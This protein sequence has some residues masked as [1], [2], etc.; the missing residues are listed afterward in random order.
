MK[1]GEK[2]K[3]IRSEYILSQSELAEKINFTKLYVNQVEK[4]QVNPSNEFV[5]RVAI[6]FNIAINILLNPNIPINDLKV[7]RK[8]F[9]I[10]DIRYLIKWFKL[11]YSTSEKYLEKLVKNICRSLNLRYWMDDKDGLVI[12]VEVYHVFEQ[13]FENEALFLNDG[14]DAFFSHKDAFKILGS[15]GSTFDVIGNSSIKKYKDNWLKFVSEIKVKFYHRRAFYFLKRDVMEYK[16][17][18][19]TITEI[20][21]ILRSDYN[22]QISE[23]I[24]RRVLSV[25]YSEF[26]IEWLPTNLKR[27]SIKIIENLV[28]YFSSSNTELRNKFS[29]Q[30]YL[31]LHD[32][33]VLPITKS[34]LTV[35]RRTY[36]NTIVIICKALNLDYEDERNLKLKY[37]DDR[38]GLT[39]GKDVYD[40]LENFF[41]NQASF[42]K[43]EN[44][45]ITFNEA[46]KILCDINSASSYDKKGDKSNQ[47]HRYNWLSFI[48]FIPVKFH[49][50]S[51]FYFLKSDVLQFKKS[52]VTTDEI[53]SI[54]IK[55]FN[56]VV[57]KTHLYRVLKSDYSD[58]KIDWLS[59]EHKYPIEILE[60]L[61]TVFPEKLI[62][63][64]EYVGLEKAAK[65]IGCNKKTLAD[66]LGDSLIK[67][68]RNQQPLVPIDIIN[69]W[70]EFKDETMTISKLMNNL[71][72]KSDTYNSSILIQKL[73]EKSIRVING[74]DTP[75]N[76]PSKYVYKVDVEQIKLLFEEILL[77]RNT[78][79]L[80][81]V[82]I[83]I[84][85]TSRLTND[86]APNTMKELYA[87]SIKRLKLKGTYFSHIFDFYK[88]I[89][90]IE[91]EIIDF[92]DNE[93]KTLLASYSKNRANKA[94]LGVCLFLTGLQNKYNTKY[95][96]KYK[97]DKENAY[98]TGTRNVS[99]YTEEQYFRFGFLILNDTHDW[100]EGYLEKALADYSLSSLW[101][102]GL[103]HYFCAWRRQ[104][105]I[106]QLPFPTLNMEPTV[107]LSLIKKNQFTEEMAF[108]ISTEVE[109]K[110]RYLNQQ[111]LK[112]T[113]RSPPNLVLEVPESA[114]FKFG[115]LLGICEAFRQL[116]NNNTLLK[117][118]KY[119]IKKQIEFFGPEFS[120]IFGG[121]GL[122]NLRLNK[123]FEILIA[124]KAD[125]KKIGTGYIIASFARSHKCKEHQ[126]SNTT[127]VYL[128]DYRT[129][130]NADIVMRELFERG[131]SSFVPYLVLKIINGEENVR[132]KPLTTQTQMIKLSTSLHAYDIETILEQ[133]NEILEKA[134][135][136]ALSIVKYFGYTNKNDDNKSI[137]N[138]VSKDLIYRFLMELLMALHQ[139]GKIILNC[140]S[141]AKG[142]GCIDLNRK[143]CIGCGQEIY[144]K[145]TIF[146]IGQKLRELKNRKIISKT[147]NEKYK[148]EQLID[149]MFK[150]V[151]K[152]ILTILQSVYGVTDMSEYRDM[153]FK[154]AKNTV[155]DKNVSN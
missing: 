29:V 122:H 98:N 52:I 155:G 28:E 44:E 86:K 154:I 79:K 68:H 146:L 61:K 53:M 94:S 71:F 50:K 24:L 70:I 72:T 65:K 120:D 48:E 125:E 10:K 147:E 103:L 25:K 127:L 89:S 83:F 43:K 4:G 7:S 116:T 58:Q 106:Q 27:Y 151:L 18:I 35:N 45:Y 73:N 109:I 23:S 34:K 9:Y 145:S 136:K 110:F 39:F 108:K 63:N 80:S 14:L 60:G 104:D 74:K 129:L 139:L 134:K 142:I 13:F 67:G 115:M 90:T 102:Y 38:A 62:E 54:F 95:K 132:M 91:K 2:I 57:S 135:L 8:E 81:N 76:T 40:V 49:Y 59:E 30:D 21:S 5:K 140:I 130:T 113:K 124:K 42:L 100:Y 85:K 105:M 64:N 19:V 137:D 55:E 1:I 101:L 47:K 69:Y 84:K 114:R 152:E 87:F 66:F 56:L 133:S 17:R 153:V 93:I 31:Q 33:Y 97:Y 138:E 16:N 119:H 107:F 36:E 131:V 15:K 118:S 121:E 92:S 78:Y 37:K 128:E 111:P 96:E 112:T 82:D 3:K 12:D 51:G 46:L 22:L 26:H 75:F 148:Y 41:I 11:S 117:N 20:Q 32:K 123:T 143:T 126:K 150:P 88:T 77:E 141:V 6:H 144:L 99:P 149:K